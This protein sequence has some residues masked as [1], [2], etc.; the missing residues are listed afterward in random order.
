MKTF[1]KW[2]L[3]VAVF[4]VNAQNSVSGKITDMLNNPL[5]D[6]QINTPE[7]HRGTTSKEDG[8]FI[9]KNIPK[10]KI[11]INFSYLG[12][13][14]VSK[15]IDFSSENIVLNIQLK[16]TAFKM[17]EVII[18]APFN[19]L[20]SENVMKIERL[21]A[22]A[23]QKTGATTLA[24]GIT[25]I[26][27]VS[28]ISTGAS[29]G[30][31]VI[32]GLSGNRVLVYTQGIR[33]ENQQF[34][35]E[36][37]LGINDA[38]ISSVEVIKG[39]ASLLYGS[40]ALGGVLYLNPEKFASDN[41]QEINFSHRYFGNTLGT[42]TSIGAKLSKENWKFLARGTYVNHSDYKIP[43][44]ERVTNTRFNERD[45]KTGV[46]YSK[47]SFTSEIRY[48]FNRSNLGLPEEGIGEQSTSKSL[49]EPYQV[50]DNHILSSHNHF[51]I[52]DSKLDLDLGYTF[53]DRQEFEEHHDH[54]EGEV[55]HDEDEHDEDHEEEGEEAALRMKLKTFS[56]NAKYHFPKIGNVEILSGVQGLHQTNTNFGEELL[57][58]NATINDFGVFTTANYS[59][60]K[61]SL[62]A[63]VRY[64]TRNIDTERHEISHEGDLHI[65]EAID[66]SYNSFTT[67]LGF[68]T[69]ITD[70]FTARINVASGF[71]AP[72]LAELSSN[73][74]HHGTGRFEKG[75]N[76]LTNEKNTQFDLS[77]EYKTEH[78]ELFA[79]GFY[80]QLN[81]YIYISPTGEIED[82]APVFEYLQED[83]K[84]YGGEFG[85]HLHPHPLDWLH[86]ESSFETVIG[87]Q[88]NGN[89]L[90]LIP[91]NSWKNTLRTEFDVKK[92]LQQGYASLTLKSTFSQNNVSQFETKTP[93]YNL[94]NFGFGGDITINDIKF[95][96]N[97]S[98]NNILDK[99]YIDHLSRLKADGI[100]NQ[101]RNI[102]LGI[103][104]K[105]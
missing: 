10:R 79:N 8:T 103:N 9:L 77:L 68:K 48:N 43:T 67:S 83:A 85:F 96:A 70:N 44:E 75:N 28:Q 40:D 102:V 37:G 18:S 61:N 5:A 57:I 71:R 25:N 22:K 23:I 35:G 3:L 92:W 90:P 26:A 42:N 45:F 39:P 30:K 58:P 69:A 95:S 84:L 72:N 80:N 15:I 51:F 88:D 20:Q 60:N 55:D 46:A 98:A 56:Y 2:L 14:T 62:Q 65:F 73:G 53:N 66:K 78:I 16:E 34:G 4:S 91:A 63:G 36:H 86:L 1:I 19:K 50:I 6:V 32:R 38:G 7:L 11:K 29:I 89:Y 99:K 54:D 17:D 12:Y 52:G 81:D 101:G 74:V 24:E 49:L 82:E 94:L 21:S 93:S 33:L 41:D 64:D 104:F 27:G 105:I 59:W 13:R 97:L 100:L 76:N 31:P 87:E 47:N